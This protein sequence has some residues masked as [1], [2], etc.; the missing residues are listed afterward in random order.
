[1]RPTNTPPSTTPNPYLEPSLACNGEALPELL[2]VGVGPVFPITVVSVT[3]CEPPGST[4]EQVL[5]DGQL[6][7]PVVPVQVVVWLLQVTDTGQLVIVMMEVEAEVIVEFGYTVD[8]L[9][10]EVGRGLETA[11]LE[12]VEEVEVEVVVT[13]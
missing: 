13:G 8:L 7:G 11:E 4:A 12:K 9:A 6:D 1:M 3:V 2:A 5:L 10:D